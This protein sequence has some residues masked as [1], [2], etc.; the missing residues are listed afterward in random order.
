VRK[1]AGEECRGGVLGKITRVRREWMYTGSE[2][3]TS[4]IEQKGVQTEKKRKKIEG[5]SR[6]EKLEPDVAMAV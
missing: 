6:K 5:K 4:F 1:A 3:T 2:H